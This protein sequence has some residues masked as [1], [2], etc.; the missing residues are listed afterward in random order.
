MCCQLY[1]QLYSQDWCSENFVCQKSLKFDFGL[2]YVCSISNNMSCCFIALCD[3]RYVACK[4][5]SV[6]SKYSFF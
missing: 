1:S 6:W 4:M 3:L 2:S 5:Y